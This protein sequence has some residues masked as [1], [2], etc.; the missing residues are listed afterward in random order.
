MKNYK[1]TNA[2]IVALSVGRNDE[3]A[4][5]MENCDDRTPRA[6]YVRALIAARS[7][8]GDGVVE[9]LGAAVADL[10]LKQRARTEADFMPYVSQLD[11]IELIIH[12][13]EIK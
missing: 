11:F 10:R 6:E 3:A 1:D 12:E 2:A 7:G 8:D 9:H 13:K 5:I 4:A